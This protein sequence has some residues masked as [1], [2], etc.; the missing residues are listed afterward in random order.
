LTTLGLGEAAA[1]NLA[2]SCRILRRTISW[3]QVSGISSWRSVSA[4]SLALR[5]VRKKVGE[6]CSM[7][8][9]AQRRRSPAQRVAAVAPEPITTTACPQVE[10]VGPGLRV[11]DAA[12]EIGHAR[13]LRRV[14]LAWR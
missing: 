5:P 6:R 3:I 2:W 14:A 7:V 11:H 12:L 13:P 10:V 8:T 4:R 9:C 1:V